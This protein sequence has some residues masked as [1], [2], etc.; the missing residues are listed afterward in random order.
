MYFLV[1]NDEKQ[2]NIFKNILKTL[3]NGGVGG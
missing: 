2:K 1:V 3:D